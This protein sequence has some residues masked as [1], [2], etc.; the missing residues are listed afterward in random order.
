MKLNIE[1][2]IAAEGFADVFQ[3][4]INSD[5][6]VALL[7]IADSLAGGLPGLAIS[8]PDEE[9]PQLFKFVA[10]CTCEA[11]LVIAEQADA[12]PSVSIVRAFLVYVGSRLAVMEGEGGLPGVLH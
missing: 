9:Y 11:C 7:R 8:V 2:Q 4:L 12:P 6:I 3:E 10:A 1:K 5:D